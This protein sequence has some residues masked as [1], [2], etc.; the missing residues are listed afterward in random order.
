L[1]GDLWCVAA[2]DPGDAG[3]FRSVIFQV[4]TVDAKSKTPIQAI[5]KSVAGWTF[6][7][8]KVE[9]IARSLPEVG[10]LSV[11]T[12]D[13]NYGALWRPLAAPRE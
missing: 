10:G 2:D 4:G 3:P 13:E 5:A 8:V 9:A 11:A 6:D 12:D 7:G 1:V